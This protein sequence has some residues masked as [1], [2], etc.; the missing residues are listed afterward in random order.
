[1]AWK[2]W[3]A[4]QHRPE[5]TQYTQTCSSLQAISQLFC[6]LKWSEFPRQLAK[7]KVERTVTKNEAPKS[8]L[9]CFKNKF[10]ADRLKIYRCSIMYFSFLLYHILNFFSAGRRGVV[11]KGRKYCIHS[12]CYLKKNNPGNN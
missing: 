12:G 4:H 8:S 3:F 6:T 2:L 7:P 9:T 1:M 5:R 10:L 11:G